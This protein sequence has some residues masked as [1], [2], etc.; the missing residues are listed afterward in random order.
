MDEVLVADR[1]LAI[2][3]SFRR[4]NLRMAAEMKKLPCHKD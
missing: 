4:G 1:P 2:S 3:V